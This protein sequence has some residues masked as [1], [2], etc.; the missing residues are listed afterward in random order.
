MST[1]LNMTG[2]SSSPLEEFLR[3]YAEVTGGMWDQVEPQVYDLLLPGREAAG[4]PEMVRL[5]FDPEAVPEHPGAQLASYGTPLVDRL[6]A[7]AV[8]RGRHITLYMVGLNLATQGVEDRLRRA[9]TL[10]QGFGLKLERARPLHF[11][12]AV[13]WFEATFVSD[14]KEQDLLTVAIDLHYGRQDRKSVV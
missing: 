14:Q 11:P 2:S 6:L 4:E 13:F 8:D 10:P 3:D 5:V 7:E 9:V 1:D 12:Q